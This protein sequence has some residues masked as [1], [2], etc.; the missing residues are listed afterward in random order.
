MRTPTNAELKTFCER[1]LWS[2]KKRTDHW[3]YTKVIDGKTWLTKVS[4]GSGQIGDPKL[5]SFILR[6]Q[7]NI[8]LNE[9]WR[10]V[11]K[12]GPAQRPAAAQPP[13]PPDLPAWL[14][15]GLLREGVPPLQLRTL[16]EDDAR[17]LL[18][19]L[20]SRPRP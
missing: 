17:R 15:A 11:D 6:E 16:N 4:F 8:D 9:F 3:R 20:R 10:V 14:E 18:D 7:L 5:F 13:L 2:P 1:D 19:E 12:G